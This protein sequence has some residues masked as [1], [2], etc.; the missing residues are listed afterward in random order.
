MCE[1]ILPK[2]S[3]NTRIDKIYDSVNISKIINQLNKKYQKIPLILI[4][5]K[6]FLFAI[7][8][9]VFYFF[10]SY[11]N[12]IISINSYY[13]FTF[14]E[15]YN[16]VPSYLTL[17]LKTWKKFLPSYYKI[18]ILDYSNIRKYLGYNLAKKILCRDMSLPIQA[19]A[20]RVAILHKYGGFWMDTDTIIM[21]SNWMDLIKSSDLQIF[22][23][24]KFNSQT[25]GFIYASKKSII[26]KAWLDEIISRIKV[27]KHRLFLKKI[28]P[29]KYNKDSYQRLRIWHYLGNGILNKLVKNASEKDFKRIDLKNTNAWPE[30]HLDKG[31]HRKKYIDFYFS[32]KDMNHFLVNCKG[33]LL[34]HNSWTPLKFK[35][36]SKEEFLQQ[37]IMLAHILNRILN[38]TI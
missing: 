38:N 22:G 5:K 15:P 32:K 8:S 7:N 6:L 2:N 17:C 13:I 37:D 26:L 4:I 1:N 28:F 34:L 14:W 21:N 33:I 31:N 19:D 23:N 18:I 29:T 24:T 25:I 35:K 30:L 10:Y 27:Y 36:M 20:I 9:F 16:S 12:K 11:N 3:Q